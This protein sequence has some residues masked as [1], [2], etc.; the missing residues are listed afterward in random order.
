MKT[1]PT[2]HVV[3]ALAGLLVGDE[4]KGGFIA[5]I[6]N[7]SPCRCGPGFCASEQGLGYFGYCGGSRA[8]AA[9]D[10]SLC[11]AP[12]QSDA[13]CWNCSVKG[14]NEPENA[15]VWVRMLRLGLRYEALA[16]MQQ[17]TAGWRSLDEVMDDVEAARASGSAP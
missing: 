2:D 15:R 13:G 10:C 17:S 7:G 6:S 1:S 12:H 11:G 8:A 3:E 16:G 4:G 5:V 9:P 14:G